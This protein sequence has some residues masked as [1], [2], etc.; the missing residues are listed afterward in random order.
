MRLAEQIKKLR[1]EK[2]LTQEML[3]IEMHTTRQ[4]ISKWEQG[5]IE[6]N[7]QMLNKLASFF[8]VSLD[9]LVNGHEVGTRG[10]MG[11]LMWLKNQS[12]PELFLHK[13]GGLYYCLSLLFV[14][15]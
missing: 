11:R 14:E 15:H 1:I 6:P 10:T 5:T 8:N 4:T 3:A 7:I 12:M 13:N 9:E 2:E